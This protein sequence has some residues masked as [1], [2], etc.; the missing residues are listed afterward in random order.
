MAATQTPNLLEGVRF[1][2]DLP[3]VMVTVVVIVTSWVLFWI[4]QIA[5]LETK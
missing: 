4:S 3:F 2:P 1:P 5:R